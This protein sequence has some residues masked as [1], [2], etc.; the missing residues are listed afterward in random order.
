DLGRF[1]NFMIY[2]R[3][4]LED[5]GSSDSFGRAVWALGVTAANGGRDE[6]RFW[7]RALLAEVLP[8]TAELTSPRTLAYCILGLTRAPEIE[9]RDHALRQ[10]AK[11][12]A[13][14]LSSDPDWTWF[15]EVLSY[16]NARLPEALLRAGHMLAD[17]DLVAV[18]LKA[19]EWLSDLEVNP[20]GCYRPV[21]TQSF[22]RR[23]AK[24]SAFD[25]QPLEA[26]AMVDACAAALACGDERWSMA[27]RRAYDW[28]LGRNDLGARMAREDG[29][30]Y[31][32]LSPYGPNLNQGAESILAFQMATC[33]IN[34]LARMAPPSTVGIRH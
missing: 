1:R 7:A 25:Q 18:G 19:L 2:D 33:T 15:E 20:A 11:R 8:Q 3:R 24:P 28:F 17:P 26:A 23:K 9:G 29:A 22:G 34:R 12:L 4:W 30:C 32:G 16:D 21:G 10:M 27:S 31:D 6:L 13:A 14:Q 5:F